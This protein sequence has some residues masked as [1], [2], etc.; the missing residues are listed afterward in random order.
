MANRFWI[1]V[2][3]YLGGMAAG[4]F[5]G[6]AGMAWLAPA[7]LSGV[8]LGFEEVLLGT[9]TAVAAGCLPFLLPFLF[10]YWIATATGVT[11]VFGSI[12]VWVVSTLVAVFTVDALFG[13]MMGITMVSVIWMAVGGVISGLVYLYLGGFARTPEPEGTHA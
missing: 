13:N 12:S 6:L 2:R 1:Q 11:G 5:A 4:A 10:C 3:A 7:P 8:R 9:L